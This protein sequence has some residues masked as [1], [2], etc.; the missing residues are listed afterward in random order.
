MEAISVRQQFQAL[1]RLAQNFSQDEKNKEN[2]DI[3][4]FIHTWIIEML[5]SNTSLSELDL[6]ITLALIK[7]I[8]KGEQLNVQMKI[9]GI[10]D[11]SPSEHQ[12]SDQQI[13][14]I[15]SNKDVGNLIKAKNPPTSLTITKTSSSSSFFP[16]SVVNTKE[17]TTPSPRPAVYQ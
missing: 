13:K 2:S 4:G 16:G 5:S 14:N 9:Q 7:T 11:I 8:Y 1:G 6:Q 12:F 3:L 15:K 10:A 17:D